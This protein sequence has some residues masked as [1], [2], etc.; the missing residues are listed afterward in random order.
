MTTPADIATRSVDL[1]A[2]TGQ[3]PRGDTLLSQSLAEPAQ[4]GMVVAGAAK[5]A[6]RILLRLLT[7]AGGMRYRPTEGSSL[8]VGLRH[9]RIRTPADAHA[10]FAFDAA[11][12]ERTCA[13][14]MTAAD[15]LDEILD[16]L[17]L[18]SIT[19]APPNVVLRIKMTT[20]AGTNRPILLPV[21]VNRWPL[22]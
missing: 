21:E 19:L 7:P 8:L 3:Q 6:Q 13:A 22:K 10:A 17:T 1:A 9:G 14:E 18:E 2:F 11:R 20:K 16:Q 5:L 4:G 12:I 15:P